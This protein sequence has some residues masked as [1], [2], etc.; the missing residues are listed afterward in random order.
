M[1]QKT[2]HTVILRGMIY[3]SKRVQN[4]IRKGKRSMEWNGEKT[5]QEILKPSPSGVTQ[6]GRNSSP[7]LVDI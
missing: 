3:Y 2:Q 5:T 4:K 1:N 7:F 6:D